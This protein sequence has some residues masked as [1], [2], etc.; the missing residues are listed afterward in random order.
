MARFDP[1]RIRHNFERTCGPAEA[2]LPNRWAA[3]PQPLNPIPEGRR[4]LGAIREL[5]E[6]R[7]AA[8]W[9]LLEPFFRE[10]ERLMSTLEVASQPAPSLPEPAKDRES[11]AALREELCN[12]LRELEDLLE[13]VAEVGFG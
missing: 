3:V 9:A 8:K 1:A 5:S 4:L 10:A 12:S 13:V 6:R 11:P 2:A 7:Y